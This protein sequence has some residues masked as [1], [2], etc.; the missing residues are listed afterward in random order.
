M[1]NPSQRPLPDNTQHSQKRNIH[2]PG[3]IRTHD[4]SRRAAVDQ[5]L[6]PRD[7]WDRLLDHTTTTKYLKTTCRNPELGSA[8]VTRAFS[9]TERERELVTQ[10]YAIATA[11][12][13]LR[14]V[15]IAYA[16]NTTNALHF[17]PAGT[18]NTTEH[19]TSRLSDGSS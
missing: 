7:Y 16:L 12:T 14:S 15:A 10:Y 3:G 8:R 9:G 4:R 2:A 17:H 5:R 13:Y 6:R 11:C 1:I 18:R 19:K